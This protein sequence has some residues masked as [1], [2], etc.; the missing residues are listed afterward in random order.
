MRAC[1]VASQGSGSRVSPLERGVV[2][3]CGGRGAV[4]ERPTYC[5]N[6]DPVF[7]GCVV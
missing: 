1:G 3:G 4:R 7:P 6:G 5:R 2:S